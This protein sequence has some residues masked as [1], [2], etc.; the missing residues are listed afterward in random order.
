MKHDDRS[1]ML[2]RIAEEFARN[3]YRTGLREPDPRVHAAM[4]RLPRE[5]FVPPDLVPR[6]YEDSA[7]PID[8][9]Q[10]ISQPFIVSLM[11]SLLRLQPHHRVLEI[12]T[13]SGYQ[14]AVLAGLVREVWSVERLPELATQAIVRLRELDCRN[15]HVR[16]GDGHLGWAEHG[17]YDGI[18][19]TCGGERV[20]G[21]LLD[22]LAPGAHLV[23]PV[24]PEH[25][26]R[27]LDVTVGV[28]G[29]PER[30]DVL[31]VRFVPFVAAAAPLRAHFELFEQQDHVGVRGF[32]ATVAEAFAQAARGLTALSTD[33]GRVRERRRVDFSCGATDSQHLLA[34]WLDAVARTMRDE[35]LVFARFEVRIES[36]LLH[37][38]GFG[39]PIDATRCAREWAGFRA[40]ADAAF[41]G[42]VPEGW[43]A[44]CAS[45][46]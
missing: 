31:G 27:L 13:G 18:V 1:D 11:S 30:R 17:P 41:V 23:M 4:A 37:A 46:L 45:A 14:A 19:V 38:T 15:V 25:D 33:P 21:A 36:D 7:L 35:G 5:R 3:A 10:S 12:G 22:Q 44:Q 8:S 29:R 20:P 40:S 9:G 34:Q 24:G 43:L 28:D 26:Q 42:L 6:A 32:G 16:V 2:A 39:E